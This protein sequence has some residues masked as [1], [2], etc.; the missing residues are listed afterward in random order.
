[1]KLAFT[2]FDLNLVVEELRRE[3]LEILYPPRD[4]GFG[5]VTAV[6]DPDGNLVELTQ[7]APR[8][9]DHLSRRRQAGQDVLARWAEHREP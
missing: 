8:W 7:L 3:G 2:V 9:F 1:V 6:H 5:R 4:L